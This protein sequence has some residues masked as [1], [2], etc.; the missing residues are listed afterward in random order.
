MLCM[1]CAHDFGLESKSIFSLKAGQFLMVFD[2]SSVYDFYTSESA[3]VADS[4][5]QLFLSEWA[6]REALEPLQVQTS[7]LKISRTAYAR[8]NWRPDS[9]LSCSALLVL[10]KLSLIF[11]S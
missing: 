10:L 11:T 8:I 6:P 9:E 7:E 2:G 1:C 5:H 3:Q 4:Y